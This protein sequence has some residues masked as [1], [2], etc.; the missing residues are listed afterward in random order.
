M[1]HSTLSLGSFRGSEIEGPKV[2]VEGPIAEVE[3][4]KV[5]VEGLKV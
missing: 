5:E 2:E 1:D 3:G 4:L